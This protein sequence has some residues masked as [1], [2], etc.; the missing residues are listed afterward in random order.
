MRASFLTR[1]PESCLDG[2]GSRPS[3]WQHSPRLSLV[4]NNT[5]LAHASNGCTRCLLSVPQD[6]PYTVAQQV[7]RSGTLAEGAP[8]W[9]PGKPQLMVCS[10][11]RTY[12]WIVKGGEDVRMDERMEQ[13]LGV[14]NGLLARHPGAA[15]HHLQARQPAGHPTGH[16]DRCSC[17]LHFPS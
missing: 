11:R 9:A 6:H 7:A 5:Q 8:H 15:A 4:Q 1:P 14:C 17:C 2:L 3:K 12:E 10:L 16:P 13:I